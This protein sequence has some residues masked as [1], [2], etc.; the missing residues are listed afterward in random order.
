LKSYHSFRS[1]RHQGGH[2][3]EW[4]VAYGDF[5]TT[6]MSLFL[7]LWISSE[8]Q[9]VRQSIEEYFRQRMTRSVRHSVG[10]LP[11]KPLVSGPTQGVRT[12]GSGQSPNS[13]LDARLVRALNELPQRFENRAIKL[14]TTPNAMEI[15]VE[16]SADQPVFTADKALLTQYGK[17]LF[18]ILGWEL[19]RHPDARIQ[20]VEELQ[21]TGSDG[22]EAPSAINLAT[23]RAQMTRDGLMGGGV[24]LNQITRISGGLAQGSTNRS[25]LRIRV[26]GKDVEP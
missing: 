14:E 21:P 24:R 4:K 8:S 7:V 20:I 22:T 17:W 15:R 13:K 16:D 3:G 2:G 6:L 11:S 19:S 25:N 5:I 1:R 26:L 23:A 18:E 10:V 12:P 9:Q